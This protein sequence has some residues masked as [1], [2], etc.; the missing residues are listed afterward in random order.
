M[1]ECTALFFCRLCKMHLLAEIRA[2]SA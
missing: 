1:P 2:D